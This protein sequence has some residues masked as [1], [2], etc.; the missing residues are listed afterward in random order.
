MALQ[1]EL[2]PTKAVQRRMIVHALT[3]LSFVERLDQYQ[4]IGFGALEFIDFDLVHRTLG[5]T[6]MT[7]IERDTMARERYEFNAPFDGV[8]V[9]MGDAH[10][11]LPTIDWSRLT[12]A[13]LDYTE[14]LTRGIVTDV[15]VVAR[16]MRPGSV[17]IVTVNAEPARPRTTRAEKLEQQLGEF[18][19]QGTTD[20]TLG[21]WGLATTQRGVLQA[22]ADRAA[23]DA[24]GGHVRQLFN[25]HY[26]DR[27]RMLTWGGIVTSVGVS[28]VIETCRFEDLDFVRTG[29]NACRLAVPVV[30]AREAAHVERQLP[31]GATRPTVPGMPSQQVD[32][33]VSIYRWHRA[34]SGSR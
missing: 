19:P 26:A 2:R 17:L 14:Q 25:F 9:A 5:I 12:I 1:Y 33:Y 32:D 18:V 29:E 21:G 34:D 11:V 15:D 28:R 4:Y 27:S 7:S 6:A 16:S 13:W 20:E 31:R 24:H 3:R 22:V 23:R 10:D 8:K 30:T